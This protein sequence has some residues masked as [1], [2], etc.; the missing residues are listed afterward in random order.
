[1]TKFHVQIS[2]APYILSLRNLGAKY[3]DKKMLR[4]IQNSSVCLGNTSANK[5]AKDL[6]ET[7]VYHVGNGFGVPRP[8]A[9]DYVCFFDS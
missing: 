5:T 7:F 1:M 9:K 8:F 6:A 4:Q 3:V 2:P